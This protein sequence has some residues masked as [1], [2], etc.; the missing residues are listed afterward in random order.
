MQMKSDKSQHLW[1]GQ[2]FLQQNEQ[3]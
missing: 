2:Q 3:I 1:Q